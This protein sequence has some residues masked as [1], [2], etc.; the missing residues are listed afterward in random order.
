M[1]NLLLI[2]CVWV[3]TTGAAPRTTFKIVAT[4]HPNAAVDVQLDG[5]SE[6]SASTHSSIVTAIAAANASGDTV[7]VHGGSYTGQ[8]QK[9]T[10]AAS[11]VVVIG[12]TGDAS[13]PTGEPGA[14][15]A[16]LTS[17]QTS[18]AVSAPETTRVDCEFRNIVVVGNA[19]ATTTAFEIS[20]SRNWLVENVRTQGPLKS[21]VQHGSGFVSGGNYGADGYTFR[22]CYFSSDYTGGSPSSDAMIIGSSSVDMA[23]DGLFENCVFDLDGMNVSQNGFQLRGVRRL[24]FQSCDIYLPFITGG[25]GRTGIKVYS[26]TTGSK[27]TTGVNFYD[28]SIIAQEAAS[29]VDQVVLSFGAVA[30]AEGIVD[31]CRVERCYIFVPERDDHF[32]IKVEADY[33]GVTT[34]DN[35]FSDNIQIHHNLVVGGRTGIGF[36]ENARNSAM[37]GNMII[38][39]GRDSSYLSIG[40]V[41]EDARRLLI[42]NNHVRN[43][44]RGLT[45]SFSGSPAAPSATTPA[46]HNNDMVVV[47]NIFQQ[48]Q[49]GFRVQVDEAGHTVAADTLLS[50]LESA[51][52]IVI[53]ADNFA[54]I[55]DGSTNGITRAQWAALTISNGDADWEHAPGDIVFESYPEALRRTGAYRSRALGGHGLVK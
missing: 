31:N 2:L 18:Y 39:P 55:D 37:T 25:T 16:I 44:Q 4:D 36:H 10:W 12:A 24:T 3:L 23:T 34:D 20:P 28:C 29:G 14:L 6:V 45:F 43:V 53:G 48:V 51:G 5:Y 15:T 52:N 54:Y 21:M 13:L 26:L 1:K 35:T 41:I 42:A 9:G 11:N 40:I 50:G 7:Y 32:G 46:F 30:A 17:T 49:E 33:D 22:D 8:I 27:F 38:G 19:S 47:G